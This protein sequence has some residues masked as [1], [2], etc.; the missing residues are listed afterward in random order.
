VNN[1]VNMIGITV[2][3]NSWNGT[4]LILSMARQARVIT[5]DAAEAG[6][7]RAWVPSTR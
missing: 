5:E 3:S 7:G 2:T 6:L 1:S 4:C